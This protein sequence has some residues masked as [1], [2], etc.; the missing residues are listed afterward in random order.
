MRRLSATD[1]EH[2]LLLLA[3]ADLELKGSKRPA[4]STVE[5]TIMQMCR[6]HAPAADF[7]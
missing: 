4:R 7:R 1:L 6:S 3:E 2:W 5:D